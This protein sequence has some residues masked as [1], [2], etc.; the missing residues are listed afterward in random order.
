MTCMIDCKVVKLIQNGNIN[1]P[2]L[3]ESY[4]KI[5]HVFPYEYN[6]AICKTTKKN[7]YVWVFYS[8]QNLWV[9]KT[10]QPDKYT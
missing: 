6:T 3:H 9:F 5:S 4:T 1:L 8:L 7:Q 2:F 10:V